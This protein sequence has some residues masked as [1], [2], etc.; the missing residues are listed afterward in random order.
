MNLKTCESQFSIGGPSVISTLLGSLTILWSPSLPG[1]GSFYDQYYIIS[2]LATGLCSLRRHIIASFLHERW[3]SLLQ[4][5]QKEMWHSR[6]LKSVH[7]ERLLFPNLIVLSKVY[8]AFANAIE[9]TRA[10]YKFIRGVLGDMSGS[11]GLTLL[12]NRWVLWR[13]T[14]PDATVYT[15]LHKYLLIIVIVYM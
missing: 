2:R 9:R 1:W 14:M 6:H 4:E 7:Q 5:H 8:N 13:V 15:F 3:S 10:Y 12:L 11:Y